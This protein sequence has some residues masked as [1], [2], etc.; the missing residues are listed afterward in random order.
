[1]RTIRQYRQRAAQRSRAAARRAVLHPQ[2]HLLVELRHL[3]Y[4]V[5]AAEEEHFGRGAKRA[6]VVQP[7]LTRAVHELEREL[8][9]QLFD[10]LARGVRLTE[11]GRVF[12]NEARAI[13]TQVSQAADRARQAARGQVGTLAIGF[14]EGL[15]FHP[16]FLDAIARFRTDYPGIELSFSPGSSALQWRRLG[17]GKVQLAIV[18]SVPRDPALQHEVVFEDPLLLALPP[19]SAALD[20]SK[21]SVT[22]L[23]GIPFVWFRREASPEFYDSVADAFA[24]AGVRPNVVQTVS[25][26]VACGSAVAAGVGASLVPASMASLLPPGVGLRPIVDF[27]AR[28][29]AHALWRADDSSPAVA[30]LLKLLRAAAARR[31]AT[32]REA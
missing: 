18:Q 4:F 9:V 28:A 15:N 30:A 13:L 22:L 24:V 32:P 10:R 31:V 20:R 5:A 29:I 1:M 16:A 26:H 23:H 2:S 3:R 11:T 8:G 17:K 21:V 6:N 7:A 12:L 27:G 25:S 14:V 19:G